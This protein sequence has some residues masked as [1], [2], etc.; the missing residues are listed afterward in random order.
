MMMKKYVNLYTRFFIVP[1]MTSALLGFMSGMLVGS[2]FNIDFTVWLICFMFA[3]DTFLYVLLRKFVNAD[4]F[5]MNYM[6]LLALIAVTLIAM[7]VTG[8]SV[9]KLYSVLGV[10]MFPALPAMFAMGLM[11]QYAEF[12]ALAA[13]LLLWNALLSYGLVYGF[14]PDKKI[15]P[16]ALTAVI[17]IAAGTVFFLNSPEYK[18]KGHSFRYMNHFSSTDFSDYMPYSNPSKLYLLDHPASLIIE[19]EEDMPVLDGAEACYPMYSSFAKNVYQNIGE[20]EK[21]YI[22]GDYEFTN[23]RYVS[24]TN[25]SQGYYRLIRGDA[26]MFFG[27]R[28][29]EDLKYYAE[30]ENKKIVLTPIAKE[31]FVFFVEADNPVESLTVQQVKDIYSGQ[32]RNWKEDGGKDQEIVA[33]QRPESSGSQVMMEYFM[34]DTPLQTPK[35]YEVFDSMTGVIQMVAEYNN[36]KGALGYTFRYFLEGLHQEENVKMLKI[37]GI[38]A[39]VENIRSGAYPLTAEVECAVLE[40]NDK[41]NVKALLDWILS[42]EGQKIVEMSGYAPVN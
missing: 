1:L 38:E 16:L 15:I 42:E 18:Y 11:G 24:F 41:P 20:I 19:K 36:E 10:F 14:R 37:D 6:L 21:K 26:D 30:S 33:F 34:G 39:S 27:A 31:G 7:L 8:G 2:I 4:L 35:T 13:G 25:S 28:P 23:G 40:S 32:I 3:S 17:V 9:Y 29:S 12:C 5:R 22:K